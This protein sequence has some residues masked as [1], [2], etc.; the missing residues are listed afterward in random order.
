MMLSQLINISWNHK[1]TEIIFRDKL[2]LS[3]KE[4]LSLTRAAD[5]H[6]DIVE[7]A[8]LSTCNRMEFYAV[9]KK[10]NII[11]YWIFNQYKHLFKR[12][13]AFEAFMPAILTGKDAV[14]HLFRV[15]GG[16]DSMVIGEKQILHQVRSMQQNLVQNNENISLLNQLII[17]AV[18]CGEEVRK[19]TQL[20]SEER[21]ISLELVKKAMKFTAD[22][23]K[24]NILLIGAGE[25]S[26]LTA[27]HFIDAGATKIVIANR[28]EERAE[29]LAETLDLH[30]I[31]Y[32]QILNVLKDMDIVVTAT[33][34]MRH[35]IKKEDIKKIFYGK[36][37]KKILFIDISSPRN[38]DPEIRQVEGITLLDIDHL[39]ALNVEDPEKQKLALAQGEEIVR[40]YGNNCIEN[41][42][43][44]TC[45]S[46]RVKKIYSIQQFDAE[47]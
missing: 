17:D 45:S 21:S 37:E 25:T 19:K 38:I 26:E 10:H 24:L 23:K 2:A 39:Q 47:F 34:S 43:S 6:H 36:K 3:H 41:L 4:I 35:L 14:E 18:S 42:Q 1:N 32:N 11:K 12:N 20:G 28:H 31:D 40:S 33:H 27:R 7:F 29:N 16:M 22:S 9:S 46:A 15:A 8:A 5:N 44:L 13:L 30:Y